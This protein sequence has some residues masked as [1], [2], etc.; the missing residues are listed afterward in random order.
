MANGNKTIILFDSENINLHNWYKVVKATFIKEYGTYKWKDSYKVTAY[1]S[2]SEKQANRS[3]NDMIRTFILD[4]SYKN[5]AD[6]H[7]VSLASKYADW[8][9]FIVSNDLGLV[10]RILS[11]N[12]EAVQMYT[13]GSKESDHKKIYLTKEIICK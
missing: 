11:I 2:K 3:W 13:A 10:Q 6:D 9:I 5:A 12:P 7:L 4:K 1:T 8:D